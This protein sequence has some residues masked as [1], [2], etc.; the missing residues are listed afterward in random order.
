MARLV[1]YLTLDFDSGHDLTGREF[2]PC[3]GLKADGAES[4]W[5]SFPLS[6]PAPL[7]HAHVLFLSD[8]L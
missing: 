6:A 8:K 2:E 5:N 3:I 7:V 1:E 4:A